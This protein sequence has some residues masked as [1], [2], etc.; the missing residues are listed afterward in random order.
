MAHALRGVAGAGVTLT[1]RSDMLTEMRPSTRHVMLRTLK[2]AGVI[3]RARS[4]VTRI[5]ADQVVFAD[6]SAIPSDFTLGAA[7]ARPYPWLSQTGLEL[8]DGFIDISATLQSSDPSIFATG[9]CAHMTHATRPKAGVFAV[10]QA[11]V[12][13][14][15]LRMSLSHQKSPPLRSYLPQKDYLKLVSLGGKSALA[16]KRGIRLRG[17]LMWRWKDHIDRKFMAKLTAPMSRKRG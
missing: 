10:R 13:F 16:D 4:D 15:N 12:L 5:E 3:L 8:T 17:A 11:P 7:G 1:D 9:D 2:N 14:E 6:G